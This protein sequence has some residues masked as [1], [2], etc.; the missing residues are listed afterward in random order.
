MSTRL[1]KPVQRKLRGSCDAHREELETSGKTPADFSARLRFTL[2]W[3]R[4]SNTAPPRQHL[5]E[6]VAEPSLF[7]QVRTGRVA[8]P[9]MQL[10]PLY[11]LLG[12]HVYVF[13]SKQWV[14]NIRIILL[15]TLQCKQQ[16]GFQDGKIGKSRSE[17]GNVGFFQ[18]N[19]KLNSELAK[20]IEHTTQRRSAEV[21]KKSQR[22]VLTRF[23]CCNSWAE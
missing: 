14:Q 17:T 1:S 10:K 21:C 8:L 23:P 9:S 12:K 18:A 13:I 4:C 7:G 11:K 5:Q 22:G 15:S 3:S 19:L 16:R 2:L 6:R 20:A